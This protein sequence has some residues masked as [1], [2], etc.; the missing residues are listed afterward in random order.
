MSIGRID[1]FI[2]IYIERDMK[3]GILTEKK[4]KN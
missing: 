4:H 3:R 2:D 1:S